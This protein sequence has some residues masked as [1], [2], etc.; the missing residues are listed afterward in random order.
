MLRNTFRFSLFLL[1]ITLL[2]WAA[3]QFF[4]QS[5]TVVLPEPESTNTLL[6]FALLTLI[7]FLISYRS[8]G[9]DR[10]T[11]VNTAYGTFSLRMFATVLYIFFYLRDRGTYSKTF[12]LLIF[13]V[14]IFYT[15]FE[16]YYLTAKLHPDL[17]RDK[18]RND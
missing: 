5:G 4:I 8:L 2:L 16:I 18:Q 15:L 17:K 14:Y 12:I 10:F 13:G 1:L 7:S 11:F 9:K 3:I 6:F